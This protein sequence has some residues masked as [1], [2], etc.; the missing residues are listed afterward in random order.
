MKSPHII[1]IGPRAIGKTTLTQKLKAESTLPIYGFVTRSIE[2]GVDGELGVYMFP[3]ALP[4]D[5]Q[6]PSEFNR[7]GMRSPSGPIAF[8]EV[9]ENLGVS[10][11]EDAKD[12]GIILMDELGFMEERAVYFQE[13]VLEILQSDAHV[14]AVIKDR[15]DIP[16][17]ERIR[18][19]G[20]AEI[21]EVTE[22]TREE[23]YRGLAT[24][25]HAWK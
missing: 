7:V 19:C 22:E 21:Y 16:F 1:L 11:L 18:G 12:D 5:Q 10:L 2:T 14:I 3:A 8:P 23:L 17:L 4:T 25:V 24:I 20:N 9:F 15:R 6:I 13:K